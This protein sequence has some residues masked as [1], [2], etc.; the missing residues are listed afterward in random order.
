MKDQVGAEEI[1]EDQATKALGE[2]FP[3]ADIEVPDEPAPT[4][5][6]PS[7]PE[8][9]VEPAVEPPVAA[10]PETPEAP[11]V[12]PDPV[13]EPETDDVVSLKARLEKSEAANKASEEQYDLR[14]EAMQKRN[15]ETRQIQQDR[16]LKKSNAAARALKIIEEAKSVG[17]VSEEDAD[18]VIAEIKGT[19]H[20]ESASYEPQP[21]QP[22]GMATED[23]TMILNAFLDEKMMTQA[24]SDA[25]GDWVRNKAAEKMS[26]PE[27]DVARTSLDGFLRLAHGRWQEGLTE[28]ADE[29]TKADA[30]AATKSVQRNQREAARA[31]STTP[32]SPRRTPAAPQETTDVSKLTHRDVDKLLRQSVE[33]SY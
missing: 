19:M 30:I 26:P 11:E 13:P 12:V 9:V 23:Q 15:A 10:A 5:A 31:A 17:G 4:A 33:E 28:I 6:E 18:R 21:E 25:F 14:V 1:T 8:P 16:Y 24:D 29:K 3:K 32:A 20:P 27:Q 2:L 7:T 22:T